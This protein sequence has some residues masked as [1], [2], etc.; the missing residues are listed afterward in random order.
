MEKGYIY[1]IF[2]NTNGNVY[3]GSTTQK[4]SMRMCGHRGGYKK[5]ME[6]KR[7]NCRSFEILKN[8]DYSYSLVE[9][10]ECDSKLIL[11]QRER[12]YIENFDCINKNIPSRTKQE[13]D[14]ANKDKIKEYREAN[15]DKISEK[16]KEYQEANK[17][18]IKAYREANKDKIKEYR[19][20][21]KEKM[22]EYRKQYMEANKEKLNEYSKQYR[23]ANKEKVK[24]K[25]KCECGC[26]VRKDN[27]SK[28]RKTKKHLDNLK[29]RN[30]Q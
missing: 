8:G 11:H 18:K 4:L 25:I 10:V 12:Y 13:Y 3:Y 14:V 22:K 5:F 6:K 16:K 17:E 21:N 23:E 9:E 29:S 7:S 30:P 27:I 19:E 15:K 24:E 1:K 2:D 28:H 26:E 20:A